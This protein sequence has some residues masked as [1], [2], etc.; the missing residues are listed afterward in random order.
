MGLVLVRQL[1]LGPKGRPELSSHSRGAPAPWT[2]DTSNLR[3]G[4]R[5][6]RRGSLRSVTP[7]GRARSWPRWAIPVRGRTPPTS[8]RTHNRPGATTGASGGRSTSWATVARANPFTPP[9]DGTVGPLALK[10]LHGAREAPLAASPSPTPSA[11]SRRST[12]SSSRGKT[13]NDSS[14]V[15]KV[16]RRRAH[17]D[18]RGRARRQPE[19]PCPGRSSCSSRSTAAGPRSASRRR[20]ARA[21]SPSSKK[22]RLTRGPVQGAGREHEREA[23]EPARGVSEVRFDGAEDALARL[24]ALAKALGNDYDRFEALVGRGVWGGG[25]RRVRPDVVAAIGGR[26][27][28]QWDRGWTSAP[29]RPRERPRRPRHRAVCRPTATSSLR[30]SGA[31]GRNVGGAAGSSRRAQAGG[32]ALNRRGALGRA[33][34]DADGELPVPHRRACDEER[35]RLRARHHRHTSRRP[36]TPRGRSR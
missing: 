6:T 36:P 3:V 15:G 16:A 11:S 9:P 8:S 24:F 4:G 1:S 5:P 19:E 22:A 28:V 26:C 33:E 23:G 34:G 2:P 18:L 12:G 7:C 10:D 29:V 30:P 27:G 13:W 31:R 14:A 17:A 32:E 21:W 35:C 20:D 25:R